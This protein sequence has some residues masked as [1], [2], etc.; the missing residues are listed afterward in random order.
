MNA[1]T[2]ME[3]KQVRLME[4]QAASMLGMR[5]GAVLMPGVERARQERALSD[6]KV[7]FFNERQ[8]NPNV[9]VFQFLKDNFKETQATA[10]ATTDSQVFQE[11]QSFT[12]KTRES[13]DKAIRDAQNPNSST[14]NADQANTLKQQ[15][16]KFEDA[17]KNGVIDENG[18]R[19]TKQ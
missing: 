7:K 5:L 16:I 1:A 15:R 2:A 18:K 17:I 6:L 13:L 3:D 9:D 14:Y 4:E 8:R 12:Y 10:T 19:I 11:I